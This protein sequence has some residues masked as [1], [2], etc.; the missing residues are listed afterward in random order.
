MGIKVLPIL[1]DRNLGEFWGR[2]QQKCLRLDRS[3]KRIEKK[4]EKLL[5]FE[6]HMREKSLLKNLF[7]N[8]NRSSTDQVPIELGRNYSS[9]F[10]KNSIDWKRGFVQSKNNFNWLSNNRVSI[11]PGRNRL[12]ILRHFRSVEK[13]PRSIKNWKNWNFE[14]Q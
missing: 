13:H 9:E 2:K 3:R 7:L 11:E 14:N 1:E 12:K 6:E 4:F 8:F 5:K 10:F